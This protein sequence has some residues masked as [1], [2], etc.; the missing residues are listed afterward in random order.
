MQGKV[1]RLALDGLLLALAAVLSYIETLVPLL[2]LPGAHLGLSHALIMLAYL[3][4]SPFDAA[5]ISL[6]RLVCVSLPFGGVTGLFM[7]AAGSLLS[8][9]TLPLLSSVTGRLG[10]CIASAAAHS[11]GQIAAAALLYGTSGL[12][13]TYYPLLLLLALPLGAASG[14]IL[15]LLETKGARLFL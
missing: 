2:P 9:L 13:F 15:Y 10:L 11:T 4:M 12:F 14:G 7:A 5:C 6:L 8:F 1:R 3:H